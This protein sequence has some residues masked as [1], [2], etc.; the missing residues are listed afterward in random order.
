MTK[1]I[2]TNKGENILVDDCDYDILNKTIWHMDKDGKT[3]R[4]YPLENQKWILRRFI[5]IKLMNKE[6]KKGELLG[7]IDQDGFNNT[8]TNLKSM[9]YSEI[10]HNKN[11]RKNRTSKF[12]GV[13]FVTQKQKWIASITINGKKISRLSKTEECAA[14]QYNLWLDEYKLVHLLALKNDIEKPIEFIDKIEKPKNIPGIFK[15]K[16]KNCTTF[17]VRVKKTSITFKTLSEAIKFRDEQNILKE[18]KKEKD[19]NEK[20]ELRKKEQPFVKNEN[21]DCILKTTT[22]NVYVIVDVKEYDNLYLIPIHVSDGYPRVRINR[23]QMLLSRYLMD[24]SELYVD[25]INRNPLDNRRINLRFVSKLQNS[26]NRTKKLNSISK[27][28]GV[29]LNKNRWVSKITINNKNI[30]LGT[31]KCEIEAAEARDIATKKY[32]GEYGNLNFP[33]K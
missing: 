31:F 25:H 4:G 11:I 32:F 18:K 2:Y 19:I 1:I 20:I 33:T 13:Y 7:H 27:Y 26:R 9:K 21:G 6:I 28:I 15:R 5:Y 14:W 8:R 12:R 30:H 29:Y 22:K 16:Y 17:M 3:I 24:E 23:K 10:I